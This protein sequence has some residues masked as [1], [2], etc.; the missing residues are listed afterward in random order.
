MLEPGEQ[1]KF[2]V[3]FNCKELLVKNNGQHLYASVGMAVGANSH[4]GV[5]EFEYLVRCG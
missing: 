2:S 3:T 4:D 1:Q 5:I